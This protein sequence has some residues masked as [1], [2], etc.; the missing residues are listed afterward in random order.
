MSRFCDLSFIFW[1]QEISVG[2]I[3][4]TGFFEPDS[5]W[6]ESSKLFQEIQSTSFVFTQLLSI[7]RQ[8]DAFYSREFAC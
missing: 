7:A 1:D 3:F 4:V 5:V 2:Q 6:V 8:N